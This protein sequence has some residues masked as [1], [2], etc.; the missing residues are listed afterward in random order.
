MN[1]KNFLIL[2]LI[3]F[4]IGIIV[5]GIS[6]FMFHYVTDSG[7]TLVWHPEAG[8][9]FV[10]DLVGMFGVLNIFASLISL[11]IGLIF[12]RNIK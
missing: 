7:I 2:S 11:L 9:P 1:K 3:T 8:K 6:Y 4:I 10:T 5:F 12:F